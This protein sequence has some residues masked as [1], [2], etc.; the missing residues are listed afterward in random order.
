MLINDGMVEMLN[1]EPDGTGLSC[2]LSNSLLE[3]L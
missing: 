1:L 2:S 3:K